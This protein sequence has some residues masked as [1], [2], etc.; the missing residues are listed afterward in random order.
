M[1]AGVNNEY[2]DRNE[3]S[4]TFETGATGTGIANR[5]HIFVS[6]MGST[7]SKEA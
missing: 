2:Q 7:V 1:L 5:T 3:K 4:C 6:G